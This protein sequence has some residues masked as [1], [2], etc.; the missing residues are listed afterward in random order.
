M[1]SSFKSLSEL[2]RALREVESSNLILGIDLTKSNTWTGE[3]SFGGKCLHA[4]DAQVQNPYQQV[5]QM[6]WETLVERMDDDSAVPVYGFGDS[7]TTDRQVF[8]FND[9]QPCSGLED[10]MY[11]YSVAARSL[12]MSGP[13]NLA[14]II[15]EAI[16]VVRSTGKYHILVIVCD[17]AVDKQH[18]AST[19]QAIV[20]ASNYPLSIVVIGVGDGPWDQMKVMDDAIPNRAADNFQFYHYTNTSPEQFKLGA[21]AEIPRQYD[22]FKN[23]TERG[24]SFQPEQP[25]F[26]YRSNQFRIPGKGEVVQNAYQPPQAAAGMA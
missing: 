18:V 15:Y 3:E 1:S 9:Y 11:R 21:L 8:S 17:G 16:D 19:H 26:L 4:L 12:K 2:Q 5:I 6:T 23:R 7:S 24:I 20:D 25:Q 10:V 14:P 13:T 22:F